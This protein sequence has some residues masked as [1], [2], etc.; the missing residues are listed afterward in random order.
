ML[1]RTDLADQ[2]SALAEEILAAIQIEFFTETGRLAIHTQT[3]YVLTLFLDLAPEDFRTRIAHDFISR[4]QKDGLHLR[5]GFVGTPFLCRVPSN[6]GHNHLAYKLLLNEDYPSW[7]YAVDLGATTI[8]ERWDSLKPDGSFSSTE[9][10]SFN[11]YT[12]GSIVEWM[13][14][15]MCGLNPSSDDDMVTGFRSARLAPKPDKTLK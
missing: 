5:T 6:I 1:G 15:D 3:G 14:R 7:L 2:Y 11:H 12:Y 9:M 8:W 4:L 10:N 13:Y